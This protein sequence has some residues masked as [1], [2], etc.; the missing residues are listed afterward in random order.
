MKKKNL[1][2]K[3]KIKPISV[4]NLSE[5]Q[6]GRIAAAGTHYEHCEPVKWSDWCTF[7]CQY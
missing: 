5:I 6:G 1:N 3:L 4:S 7:T 2:K